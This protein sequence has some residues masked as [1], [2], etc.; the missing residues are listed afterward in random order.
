MYDHETGSL[1]PQ[2]W[3]GAVSGTEAAKSTWLVQHP[4]TET[5]WGKWRELHP[6]T[7][8]LSSDT[9]YARDYTSYPYGSYRT[10]DGNTFRETTPPP[11][12]RYPNKA[13]VFGLVDR[14]AGAARAY[15]H[16]DLAQKLGE[17][18]VL[19]DSFNGRPIVVVFEK[20]S[21]LVLVFDALTADGKLT[22]DAASFAP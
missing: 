8:V 10:D 9:G 21:Q 20:D 13:M 16:V 17:R 1:W 7:L 18:G 5:T 12:G 6:D 14:A 22:F 11:D 2:L 15:P 3:M 19:N 4:A